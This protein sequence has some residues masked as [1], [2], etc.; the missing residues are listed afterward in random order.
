MLGRCHTEGSGISV[1]ILVR[2]TSVSMYL[3]LQPVIVVMGH[4]VVQDMLVNDAL[5]GYVLPD[6]GLRGATG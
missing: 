1:A 5:A 3:M 4:V 2:E 6:A